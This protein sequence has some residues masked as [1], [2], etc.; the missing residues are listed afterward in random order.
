MPFSMPT[1]EWMVR[2]IRI[3]HIA[4]YLYH[5][6]DSEKLYPKATS[7]ETYESQ[8]EQSENES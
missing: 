3:T 5:D 8:S 7:L 2:V 6:G 1:T 4:S